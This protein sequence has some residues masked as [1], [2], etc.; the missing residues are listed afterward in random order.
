MKNY[1]GYRIAVIGHTDNVP[2]RRGSKYDS[3]M[4]L[5]SARASVAARYLIEEK[6]I[7]QTKIEW[8]GKG[9]Y[10]PVADNSTEEG[11]IQNRRIEIRIYNSMN[12]D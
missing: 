1:D 7:D 5:S 4:E 10:D 2:V 3:N 8:T 12:S 9:E 6:G 11:R